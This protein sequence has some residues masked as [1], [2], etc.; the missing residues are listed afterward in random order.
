MKPAIL[1]TIA[2][3]SGILAAPLLGDEASDKAAA[4]ARAL[5]KIKQKLAAQSSQ[6]YTLKYHAS[7]GEQMDWKVS[8]VAQTETKIIGNMQTS[9]S[10][11]LSIK[12]WNVLDVDKSGNI[13]FSHMVTEVD[14][15]HK[16]SD[17]PEIR[18]N[19]RDKKLPPVGYEHIA[20]TIGKPLSTFTVTDTGQVKRRDSEHKKMSFGLGQVTM[21]LPDHPIKIGHRWASPGEVRVR[22]EDK[23]VKKV[24]I[25]HVHMLRSVVDGL[26]TIQ[27]TTEVLSPV[28]D[29]RVKS[30]LVQQLTSGEVQFDMKKGRI[31]RKEMNWDETV[32]GFN[33]PNSSMRYLA[34]FTETLQ[35]PAAK[36][37]AATSTS[38]PTPAAVAATTPQEATSAS[39]Y[40]APP[41]PAD[42][43]RTARKLDDKK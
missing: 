25:R 26:A 39:E 10:R 31:I 19:S 20:S 34:K 30:Q 21:P 2:I 3:L 37:A 8:H 16:I 22:Q 7:P 42:E 43:I 40:D 32:I 5:A 35:E 14:M 38:E 1:F 15:W 12:R 33:G 18:Y 6:T 24:K 9:R 23:T 13:K 4:N 29:A 11:S 28:N 41:E 27:I 36:T 17:R